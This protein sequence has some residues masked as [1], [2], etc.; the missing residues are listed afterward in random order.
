MTRIC[1]AKFILSNNLY[2][3]ELIKIRE[4]G[5]MFKELTL[6]SLVVV[7][8]QAVSFAFISKGITRDRPRTIKGWDR[9]TSK[10]ITQ[11]GKF[12]RIHLAPYC[13]FITQGIYYWSVLL[14]RNGGR[15]GLWLWIS[16]WLIHCWTQIVH[17]SSGWE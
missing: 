15:N 3:T 6:I 2:R 7:S 12:S 14:N 11:S 9:S 13:F 4:A 8:I 10:T 16:Q 17:V 1:C 5:K